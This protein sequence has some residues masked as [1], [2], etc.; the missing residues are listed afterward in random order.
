MKI[1]VY[2]AGVLGSYIAHVLFSGGNDVTIFAQGKRLEELNEN[3]IIT[4]HFVKFKTT[5]DKVKVI[6]S[7]LSGEIYDIIFVAVKYT[8]IKNILPILTENKSRHIVFVGN[9]SNPDLIQNYI[10][11]KSSIRKEIAFGFENASGHFENGCLICSRKSDHIQIGGIRETILWRSVI[12]KAFENTKHKVN[13][14]DNME[15]FLKTHA[16]FILPL[17][18]AAYASQGKVGGKLLNQAIDA[19]DEGYQLLETL[20]Y[21][22]VPQNELQS[23][24]EN[25][26]KLYRKIKLMKVTSLPN[27][28]ASDY[29]VMDDVKET[30]ALSSEFDRLKQM[31][32]IST[33]NWDALEMHIKETQNL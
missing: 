25:R 26:G 21:S 23:V 10:K 6:D 31:A 15:S 5:K 19:I 28:A 13:Y 7:L 22:I 18:Y 3:G 20:G 16:A 2:G 27:F 8:E 12:D 32:G 33:P 9:N 29:E 14:F 1:L 30:L 11:K 17:C 4:G 24:R